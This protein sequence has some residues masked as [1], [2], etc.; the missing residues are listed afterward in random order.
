MP[1]LG[2]DEVVPHETPVHVTFDW[3]M[4]SGYWNPTHFDTR[5]GTP[6]PL[7]HG[8][9]NMALVLHDVVR[10]WAAGDASRIREVTLGSLPAPHYPSEP[11]ETHLWRAAGGHV[12]ARLVVPA[13]GRIDG[14][15]GDKIVVDRIEIALE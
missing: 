2:A 12:R 11:T 9:R 1:E 13:S 3:A 15:A 14:G 10:C 8:P 6:A 5:A 4:A 7:V